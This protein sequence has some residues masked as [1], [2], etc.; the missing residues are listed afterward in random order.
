MMRRILIVLLLVA[1]LLL[2]LAS[3]IL[4]AEWPRLSAQGISASC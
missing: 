4:A 1:L 2:A 3:G